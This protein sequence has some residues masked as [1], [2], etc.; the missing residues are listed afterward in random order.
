MSR[1]K[2]CKEWLLGSRSQRPPPRLAADARK[3]RGAAAER[4]AACYLKGEGFNILGRN[5]HFSRGVPYELDMVAMEGRTL[6]FVEVRFKSSAR[7]GDAVESIN[8][9]KQQHIIQAARMYLRENSRRLPRYTS[10]RFDVVGITGGQ[11]RHIR[12]AF[13]T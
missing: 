10:C 8:R 4:N 6:V 11:L 1:G 9:K 13:T 2:A 3:K 7:Y 12:G 5:I